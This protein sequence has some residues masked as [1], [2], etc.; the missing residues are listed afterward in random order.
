MGKEAKVFHSRELFGGEKSCPVL[1]QKKKGK[2]RHWEKP[3]GGGPL[4]NEKGGEEAYHR[5]CLL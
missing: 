4:I 3:G 1:S 5:F 2:K